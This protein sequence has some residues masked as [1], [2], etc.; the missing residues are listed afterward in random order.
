VGSAGLDPANLEDFDTLWRA[1]DTRYA[2]IGE[3]REAWKKARAVWRAKAGAAKTRAELVLAFEGAL[4]H[5]RDDHVGLTEHAPGS[6]RRIP[7]DADAWAQW[8]DGA[9]RVTAVRAFSDSDVAGLRPGHAVTHVNGRAI[10]HVV[11]ERLRAVG[12]S[13]AAAMDWALR[14]AIAG[15]RDG[16]VKLTVRAPGEARTLVVER[17]GNGA[18]TGAPLLAR[19][20]GEDRELGYIRIR[21]T[22]GDPAL[23]NAFDAALHYLKDTKALLLDLRETMDGGSPE[24]AEAI[25]ARLLNGG[26][27]PTLIVLV[28]RWTAGEGEA[29]A[30]ALHDKASATLVGTAM[31]GLRGR[32]REVKLPHSGIVVR[33][34]G[35]KALLANGAPRETLRPTV[36][37]DLAAPSGGP[38]DPILYQALKVF[39]DPVPV[40]G[41]PPFTFS[42]TRRSKRSTLTTTRSCVPPPITSRSSSA[43]TR[44]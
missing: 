27:S 44:K 42:C 34:P 35:E 8:I 10:D 1:I 25:L 6:A 36:E 3:A 9:A 32:L 18:T 14:H 21:N 5:L 41:P 19:R 22:L 17:H 4:A 38:G 20:M 13:G 26:R 7:A 33:F 43:V 15:P 2:Y 29:L 40:G 11:A 30:A 24:V 23:P 12:G 39:S 28:D 37:I 31:A 16:A